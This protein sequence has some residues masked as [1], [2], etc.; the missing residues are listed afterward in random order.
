MH[1]EA[2]ECLHAGFK[3]QVLRLLL[4]CRSVL[5]GSDFQTNCSYGKNSQRETKS[6]GMCLKMQ[7][8]IYLQLLGIRPSLSSL[9]FLLISVWEAVCR[10]RPEKKSKYE[11]GIKFLLNDGLMLYKVGW[12]NAYRKATRWM[13]SLF[14]KVIIEGS[15]HHGSKRDPAHAGDD[16]RVEV[17][18]VKLFLCCCMITNSS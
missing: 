7:K 11:E 1:F 3:S 17:C 14:N 8:R 16:G 2:F 12:S 15:S 18:E 4:A 13:C 5:L 10:S 9:P 6:L